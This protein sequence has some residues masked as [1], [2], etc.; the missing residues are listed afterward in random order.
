MTAS[1]TITLT[2]DD[3]PDGYVTVDF[4]I[5]G[6][7]LKEGMTDDELPPALVLGAK[8]VALSRNLPG[9]DDDPGDPTLLRL[10]DQAD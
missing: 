4:D 10:W 9:D 7:A 8:M 6:Y 3:D 2:E 5:G 1:M